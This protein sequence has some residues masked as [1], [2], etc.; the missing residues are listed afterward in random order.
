MGHS[1]RLLYTAAMRTLLSLLFLVIGFLMLV[2]CV[3]TTSTSIHLKR[4]GVTGLGHV[5]GSAT[6]NTSRGGRTLYAPVVEFVTRSGEKVT[7]QS[8]IY[9]RTALPPGKLVTVLYDPA[10]PHEARIDSFTEIWVFPL[11]GFVGGLIL[12]FGGGVAF[13]RALRGQA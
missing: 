11:V 1:P 5:T 4:D 6:D 2:W 8:R 10:N 12:I 13:S 9:T 3:S 7:Y